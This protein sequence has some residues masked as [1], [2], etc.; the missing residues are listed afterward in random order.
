MNSTGLW[1]SPGNWIATGFCN[2]V[3]TPLTSQP[4][5]FTIQQA[6]VRAQRGGESKRQRHE[7]GEGEDMSETEPTVIVVDDDSS[8]RSS[9]RHALNSAGFAVQCFA[10]GAEFLS[11]GRPD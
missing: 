11:G 6:S 10:E 3:V 8:F 9:A 2:G 7:R 5:C 4:L 1:A